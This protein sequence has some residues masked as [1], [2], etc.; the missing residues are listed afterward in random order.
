ME[1][2]G[3]FS[4]NVLVPRCLFNRKIKISLFVRC[5]LRFHLNIQYAFYRAWFHSH[6]HCH[7]I[8]CTVRVPTLPWL[9]RNMNTASGLLRGSLRLGCV[10]PVSSPC[11]RVRFACLVCAWALRM[12]QSVDGTH[13]AGH[14][15]REEKSSIRKIRNKH[16]GNKPLIINDCRPNKSHVTTQHSH[17]VKCC[18]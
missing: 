11:L 17:N 3:L 7:S 5:F 13:K 14:H 15:E 8:P 4:W 2:L 16:K 12:A 6:M 10:S 1:S 9:T 18:A